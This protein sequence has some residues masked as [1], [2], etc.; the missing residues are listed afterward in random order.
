M[1]LCAALICAS[2]CRRSVDLPTP[3]S[4]PISTTSPATKPPPRTRSSSPTPLGMRCASRALTSAR[5]FSSELFATP[6][7]RCFAALSAM[8][9]TSVFH[10]PQC[11]HCP[12]HFGDSPPHSVQARSEEHTSELQSHSDLVCRLLLEKK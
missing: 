8:L 10:A 6:A 5:R 1:D 7:K 2:A 12:C 11:G 4:P 3:G 9:S